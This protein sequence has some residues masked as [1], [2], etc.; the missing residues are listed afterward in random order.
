MRSI[1]PDRID[2]LFRLAGVEPKVANVMKAVSALEGGFESI[3]TYDTG[4]VSVG[5][6]QF[7]SLKAGAGSLGVMMLRYKTADSSDFDRDFRQFG[8]DVTSSGQ[9]AVLD[10]HRAK[11]FRAPMQTPRSSPT[12]D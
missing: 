1:S 2:H 10:P 11:N 8:V 7:A 4:F 9:L 5:F 6:I 3:N 12:S